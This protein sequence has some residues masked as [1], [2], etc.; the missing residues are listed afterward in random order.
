MAYAPTANIQPQVI[1]AKSEQKYTSACAGVQT[2]HRD[3]DLETA[4]LR[5]PARGPGP[6]CISDLDACATLSR[7]QPLNSLVLQAYA[8]PKVKARAGPNA[9]NSAPLKGWTKEALAANKKHPLSERLLASGIGLG[10]TSADYARW[11]S[12]VVKTQIVSSQLSDDVIK[13]IGPSLDK[14]KGCDIVDL[15]PG[16]GLWSQKLHEYLQPRSHLLVEPAWD[17]YGEFLQPLLDKPDSKY[18]H[19]KIDPCDFNALETLPQYLRHQK[20]SLKG[21]ARPP[22]PNDSI[23]IT[24]GLIWDPQLP[25]YGLSSMARQVLLRLTEFAQARKI[26]H[27]F[28]PARMLFWTSTEEMRYFLARS[29]NAMGRLDF[30]VK[31]AADLT[32][33]VTSAHT[34]RG[35]GKILATRAP[36]YEFE[37]VIKAMERGRNQGMELPP[38]R[39]GPIHEFAEDLARLSNGTRILGSIDIQ[40]Y[41]KEQELLGK[42][43]AGL[44]SE[45]FRNFFH[46]E[47]DVGV[48]NYRSVTQS[49]VRLMDQEARAKRK[50]FTLSLANSKKM[51][52]EFQ[53]RDDLADAAENIYLKEVEILTTTDDKSKDSL[54]KELDKMKKAF[55]ARLK[56][57]SPKPLRTQVATDID[58]RLNLR[59]P[60]R[61]I[62]WDLRPYEPLV[63]QPNE[64]WP[65][66]RVS[67]FDIQPFPAV[68]YKTSANED[69]DMAD[70]L[71]DFIHGLMS[72]QAAVNKSLPE[73]LDDVAN[74]LSELV[75]TIPILKDPSK[76]GRYDMEAFKVKFLTPEM[77]EA[78]F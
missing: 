55:Q 41:L 4:S 10:D 1:S 3:A 12:S 76:G 21:D 77:V 69:G 8:T 68:Q 78:V 11:R 48:D 42:D 58:D 24:G 45:Y 20:Q 52:K 26:M 2:T 17:K 30:L 5:P 61:R 73:A 29:P 7:F 49:E 34:S 28:G 53:L 39:R 51:E 75:D 40:T 18:E 50:E 57:L 23:L 60:G 35:A 65:S 33:V 74:G 14:H 44:L 66:N 19:V 6:M 47:A 31:R 13:Y 72:G 38:H 71:N 59:M 43:T 22:Q 15:N 56:M 70:Y 37:S 25:G 54:I 64:V 16:A 63:M 9:S 62:P 36:R 32:E 46:K 67:L 27:T